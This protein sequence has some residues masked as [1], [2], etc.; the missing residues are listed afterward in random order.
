MKVSDVLAVSEIYSEERV[1]A[2]EGTREIQESIKHTHRLANK[3][4]VMTLLG[5]RALLADAGESSLEFDVSEA[6]LL[7]W[8]KEEAA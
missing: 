5:L 3:M 2:A 8:L 4:L 6:E 7:A 1:M